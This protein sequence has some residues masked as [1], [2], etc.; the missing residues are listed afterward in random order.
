MRALPSQV[1]DY[2]NEIEANNAI[3][4]KAMRR[5]ARLERKIGRHASKS[6]QND[7]EMIVAHNIYDLAE[8]TEQLYKEW[9]RKH[10]KESIV[11][12][13]VDTVNGVDTGDFEITII[14]ATDR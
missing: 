9:K 2:A 3:I 14:A 8:W 13:Q 11:K 10:R 1:H 7:P 6:A 5:N 12:C 4:E